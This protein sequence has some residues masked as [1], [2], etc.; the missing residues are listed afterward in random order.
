[1]RTGL[2]TLLVVALIGAASAPAAEHERLVVR[3]SA[4]RKARVAV[5][6]VTEDGRIVGSRL[7]QELSEAL[8]F[9]L[10]NSGY[11]RVVPDARGVAEAQRRDVESGKVLLPNWRELDAELVFKTDVRRS[12]AKLAIRCLAYESNTGKL[13]LKRTVQG[14]EESGRRLIHALS[15]EIVKVLVGAEGIARTQIAFIKDNPGGGRDLYL[16]DYDGHN[17]RRVTRDGGVAVSPDWSPD[18]KQIYYTSMHKGEPYLYRIDLA[19]SKRIAV[20]TYPGLNYA[21]AVSPDGTTLAVVL[22]KSG[23]PDV[24]TMDANG[25]NLKRLTRSVGQLSTC[26]VWSHDGRRIA[27]VSTVSGGP[28]LYVMRADGSGQRRLLKGYVEMTS[29]DWSPAAETGHLIVFSARTH[30]RRQLFAADVKKNVVTQLTFDPANHEDPNFAPDGRHIVY[31]REPRSGAADLYMLDVF[32]PKP[33]RITQTDGS[34]F[35]PAWS[36]AG[37]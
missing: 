26:P 13:V 15:D 33:V 18:A 35:Y 1:M 36:P 3:K 17:L 30:G 23:T 29:L 16:V 19:H 22:S 8:R 20:A 9:D 11:Y 24:Y 12:G 32:D 37:Y 21:A 27:Y 34:E 25:G 7:S 4:V 10:D 5:P 6:D 28:Q 31:V 2:L 14:P